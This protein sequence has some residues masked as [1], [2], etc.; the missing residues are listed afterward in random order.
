MF[1]VSFVFVASLFIL[2]AGNMEKIMFWSFLIGNI[3]YYAVGVI[4]AYVLKDNRAFCKYICPITVFLKPM[5]YYSAMRI[6]CDKANCVSCGKCK[7]VC[8]MDVDMTDNSRSRV[9]GTECILCMECVE[10]CPK[11]ALK[12]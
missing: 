6:T 7:K 4:L 5:S 2:R 10:V 8:P 3:V 12:L 11:K 1:V 9:N